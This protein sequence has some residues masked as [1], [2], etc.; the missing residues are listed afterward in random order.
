MP[1]PYHGECLCGAVQ[2]SIPSEPQAVLTC[3]C[4]HCR[5][6]AG[7]SYQVVSSDKR[8]SPNV[9]LI[10]RDLDWE[11]LFAWCG[12]PWARQ[13]CDLLAQRYWK[14]ISKAKVFLSKVRSYAVD[15]AG[16]RNRNIFDGSHR[17]PAWRVSQL[18][19]RNLS[20]HGHTL[21][22]SLLAWSFD[23][24][25][26]FTRKTGQHGRGQLRAPHNGRAPA[27]EGSRNC[28]PCL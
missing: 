20:T 4:E 9:M 13:Y 26:S 25:V 18:V 16:I 6:N 8:E 21:T 12:D 22:F 7:S 19:G 1:A 28:Q 3:A 10:A 23:L 15:G 27:I 14:R 17:Y 5:K 11:I 24:R 2:V